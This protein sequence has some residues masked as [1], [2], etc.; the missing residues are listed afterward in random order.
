MAFGEVES[1]TRSI[2]YP[3]SGS[4]KAISAM[5]DKKIDKKNRKQKHTIAKSMADLTQ[6]PSFASGRLAAFSRRA[7]GSFR[8]QFTHLS[9]PHPKTTQGVGKAG[10]RR[11]CTFGTGKD[12]ASGWHRERRWMNYK[13]ALGASSNGLSPFGLPSHLVPLAQRSITIHPHND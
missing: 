3:N 8:W 11:I 9:I 10:K 1:L 6:H 2:D 7:S 4:G 13:S 5:N 12:F